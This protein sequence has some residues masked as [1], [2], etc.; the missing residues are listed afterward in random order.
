MNYWMTLKDLKKK[1]HHKTYS[2]KC[3][4]FTCMRWAWHLFPLMLTSSASTRLQRK[5]PHLKSQTRKSNELKQ[6]S[7]I[8]LGGY[9]RLIDLFS[10]RFLVE[11]LKSARLMVLAE[12]WRRSGCWWEDDGCFCSRGGCGRRGPASRGTRKK[13]T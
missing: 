3:K 4:L 13:K 10:L 1:K 5:W 2:L 7:T 6:M 9:E 11:L 12:W 8:T